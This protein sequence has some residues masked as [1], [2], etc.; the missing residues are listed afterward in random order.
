MRK[1]SE[2]VLAVVFVVGAAA[3]GCGGSNSESANLPL[4]APITGLIA[5][6]WN[7]VDFPD[8]SCGDGSTTGIGINPGTSSDLVIFLD[9]GG[10]CASG[11]TCFSNSKTV[12]TLG[13]IAANEFDQSIGGYTGTLFD[14]T[15]T[16]NPFANATLVFVPYCTGDVHSGDRIATYTDSPAGT[17]HHMGHTNVLAFMKRLAA[18][19][20]APAHLAVTGSSAGGFGT[21]VNY[22]SI[23]AYYPSAQSV[24]IDDSGPALESNGG[25]LIQAGYANWGIADVIDPLCGGPGI[26]EADLSKGFSALIKKYPSD[27]LSL[28]SWQQDEVIAFFYIISLAEFTTELTQMT[29]DVIMPSA[30]AA[31]YIAAGSPDHTLLPRHPASIVQNGVTL[32]DWITEQ[33]DGSSAWTT[34]QP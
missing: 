25:S 17:V 23:R 18:T 32:L 15:V 21:L 2:L 7:W 8:S 20:A 28:L 13:P 19:Y 14:R 6:Q 33:V 4:G 30:N 10:A 27:R 24:L 29:A 26:C 11:S 34:V 12:A 1:S 5:Q 22:E 31:A 3:A 9:V 16:G